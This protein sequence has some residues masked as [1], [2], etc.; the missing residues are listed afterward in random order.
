LYWRDAIYVFKQENRLKVSENFSEDI[1][2]FKHFIVTVKLFTSYSSIIL[3]RPFVNTYL[4]LFLFF[5]SA[6]NPV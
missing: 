4:V 3:Q 2:E 1:Y 5:T 6:R